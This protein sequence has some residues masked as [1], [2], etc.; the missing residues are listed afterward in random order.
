MRPGY[1]T[2]HSRNALG[3][4]AQVTE[5]AARLDLAI[6]GPWATVTATTASA[7]PASAIGHDRTR[8]IRYD[9]RGLKQSERQQDVLLGVVTGTEASTQQATWR[10]ADVVT[11]YQYDGVGNVLSVLG[12]AYDKGETP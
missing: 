4:D 2:D 11:D 10:A 1:V 12:T 3:E 7:N 5:Y 6:S 8:V 9:R